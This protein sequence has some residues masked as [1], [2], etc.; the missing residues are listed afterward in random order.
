M[1]SVQRSTVTQV[2]GML[3]AAGAIRYRRAQFTIVDRDTL[4]A[5][6]CECYGIIR[7]QFDHPLS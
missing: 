1:L 6:A 7:A 3:R 4:E 2:A 5:A